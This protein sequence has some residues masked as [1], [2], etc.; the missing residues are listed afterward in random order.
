MVPPCRHILRTRL[1]GTCLWV[2]AGPLRKQ[3]SHGQ[4]QRHWS[5]LVSPEVSRL[6]LLRA[7]QDV[8]QLC[9]PFF[10][11]TAHLCH[12]CGEAAV[13]GWPGLR[14][15]FFSQTV[16]A[17]WGL[18]AVVCQHLSWSLLHSDSRS[19]TRR[20]VPAFL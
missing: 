3:K 12:R 6:L 20:N 9:G 4:F 13:K 19:K 5:F 17:R 16:Q 7:R 10:R 1:M 2:C 8:F 18:W 14:C 11:H 15:L